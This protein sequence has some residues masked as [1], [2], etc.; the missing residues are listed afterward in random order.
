MKKFLTSAIFVLAFAAF[1]IDQYFKST[2]TTLASR[3]PVA[4]SATEPSA[5]SAAPPPNPIPEPLPNP[6]AQPAPPAP[7]PAPA[8]APAPKPKGQYADGTYTGSSVY[9]YYGY[10]QVKATIS[11]GKLTDVTFLKY[12]NDRGRSVEIN[13][14]ATPILSQEAITAQSASVDGV[15]GATDTSQGF[16]ESLS[17]A[18]SQAKV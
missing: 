13:S 4:V 8:P 5:I 11:G 3:S 7:T 6:S 9:A 2:V 10:V 17:S 18:L 1:S 15:T 14:Y 12:P 16:R